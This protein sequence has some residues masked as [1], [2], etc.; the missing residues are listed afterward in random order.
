MEMR[1]NH[2]TRNFANGFEI[3]TENYCDQPYVVKCSDGAWLC[4]LTTGVGFE[5]QK[6]EHV[7]SMRSTDAGRTWADRVAIEPPEGPESS[8]GVLLRTPGGRIFCFYN[9]NTDNVRS[10]PID[11]AVGGNPNRVDTLGHFVLKYSD[12]NGK[13]WSADRIDIPIRETSIDRENVTGGEIKF[14]WNVGKPFVRDGAVYVTIHKVGMSGMGG[15]R[16]V[17][18]GWFLRSDDLLTNG[19]PEKATWETLPSGDTGLTAPERCGSIAEEQSAVVLEDGSI[20]CTYRTEAGSAACAYSRDGG[21]TW[22]A[23]ELMEETPG[24]RRMKHPRAA[25]FVWK[26]SNGRY[27]LWHHNN[28]TN[29]YNHSATAGNRNIAWLSAGTEIGGRIHWSQPEIVSYVDNPLRGSSYPDLL[30]D[31][32]R[33][34]LFSTQKDEAR[35]T[36][37]DP[38]LI[39]GLFRQTGACDQ[40]V[41]GIELDLE[42][43]GCAPGSEHPAPEI[44]SLCGE[45]ISTQERR[46]PIDGRGGFTV[47]L[48]VS[49]D[50]LAPGQILIDTR[51]LPGEGTPW[52]EVPPGQALGAT[53]GRGL[54][55]RTT[56]D[57]RLRIELFDGQ[58]GAFWDTDPR[59]IDTAS[60]HHIGVFVDGGPKVIGFVLDGLLC[61]GGEDLPYGWGRFN[62]SL[63]NL[64]GSKRIRVASGLHG[65]IDALRIYSRALRV[66]E[67][68]A[69]YRA[70]S[71]STS[72]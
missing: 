62:P 20:F 48:A 71:K 9:H 67:I 32:G 60:P 37:I 5:G 53:V 45:R 61:N 10:V 52:C 17:S 22:E 54:V 18:E 66:S 69:D 38:S 70:W 55:L 42:A 11:P 12:D 26:C 34:Y 2:D 59:I 13:S 3:P 6:G 21:Y 40:T 4:V 24:G 41:E 39:D 50:D 68:I 23:P 51:E 29:N 15:R 16:S 31:D 25:H 28:G 65:T 43:A 14:F 58:N 63:R 7:V 47:E 56:D 19:D 44:P 30:E 72:G 46:Y 57:E 64:N 27:L 36:E 35:V 49:F 1:M 8:Y 33:Y